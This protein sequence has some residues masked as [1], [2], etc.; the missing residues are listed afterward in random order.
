MIGR[1]SMAGIGVGG[2][3]LAERE[4]G[5]RFSN[6]WR[7]PRTVRLGVQKVLAQLCLASERMPSRMICHECKMS[8]LAKD[9][10]L[11]SSIACSK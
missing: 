6:R 4:G 5:I 1:L 11:I 7:Y 2:S 10:D 9:L 3:R 8:Q